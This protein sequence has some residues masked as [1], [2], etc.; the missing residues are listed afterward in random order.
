MYGK[1]R[2]G[3]GILYIV[4]EL[5][6]FWWILDTQSTQLATVIVGTFFTAYPETMNSCRKMTIGR[7]L[8]NLAGNIIC[9][10]WPQTTLLLVRSASHDYNNYTTSIWRPLFKFP[11]KKSYNLNLHAR[12]FCVRCARLSAQYD[13][14]YGAFFI[15]KRLFPSVL[16]D[17]GWNLIGNLFNFHNRNVT[18]QTKI[19]KYAVWIC[20]VI[21]LVIQ[22]IQCTAIFF[23]I[24]FRRSYFNSYSVSSFAILTNTSPVPG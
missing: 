5:Y 16:W 22:S 1:G 11:N 20:L 7:I 18:S 17:V 6:I 9:T 23:Y 12:E 10:L 8:Y 14:P 4:S 13:T 3:E 24:L 19:R 21:C 15:A 2:E